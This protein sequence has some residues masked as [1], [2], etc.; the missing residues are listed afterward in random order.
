MRHFAHHIGDYAAATAHLSFVEDAAYH[1]LLRL[2]YRDERALPSEVA[3]CQR[4]VGARTKDE[5]AA[6]E[7]VLREFFTL[8]DDGWHQTRADGEIAIYHKRATAGAGG[9]ESRWGTPKDAAAKKRSQR[10]SAARAKARHTDEEWQE[11]LDVFGRQCVKCHANQ[12]DLIGGTICKDH[13]VPIYSG[14]DDGI[15]NL[16]PMCRECNTSKGKNTGDLRDTACPDWKKRLAKRL[17]ERVATIPHEPVTNNQEP[18]EEQISSAFALFND[19]AKRTG[20]PAAQR[21]DEDRRKKM[22]ARLKDA[23]G[24]DGFAVAVGKAEASEFL[25][26]T[27]PNFNIDWLLKPANFTKLMEGNYDQRNGANKGRSGLSAALAGLAD[28]PAGRPAS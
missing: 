15:W 6:V 27:W 8:D 5:R 9:A 18:V 16:Q 28:E 24:I 23:G 26:V 25:T 17:A 22:Q 3:A 11:L 13:V 21:L 19:A 10:L 2:Y 12:G 1:R 4:L 7:T 20:W 14:G